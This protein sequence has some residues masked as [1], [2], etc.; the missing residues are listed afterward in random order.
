M[1]PDKPAKSRGNFPPTGDSVKVGNL[2]IPS[3]FSK[4]KGYYPAKLVVAVEERG[5][6]P[7]LVSLEGEEGYRFESDLI[8]VSS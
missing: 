5:D 7:N 1:K 8:I 4:Y 3:S 2:V 6:K